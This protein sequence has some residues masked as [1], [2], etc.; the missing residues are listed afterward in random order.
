MPPTK[1]RGSKTP[2]P[3]S[4]TRALTDDSDSGDNGDIPTWDTSVGP[5]LAQFLE[6]VEPFVYEHVRGSLQLI[7]KGY[8]FVKGHNPG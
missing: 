3:R 2:K 4:S 5:A 1:W 6:D 8:H 7:E